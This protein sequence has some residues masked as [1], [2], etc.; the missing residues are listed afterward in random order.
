MCW[1]EH[2]ILTNDDSCSGIELCDQCDTY[3][4]LL[5][6]INGNDLGAYCTDDYS[7][8]I[9]CTAASADICV[10]VLKSDIFFNYPP[11]NINQNVRGRKHL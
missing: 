5:S 7:G 9:D 10:S 1:C 2:G 6:Q 11:S 8:T 3:Y 4:V